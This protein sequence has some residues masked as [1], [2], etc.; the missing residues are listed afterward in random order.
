MNSFPAKMTAWTA[1][2]D[3]SFSDAMTTATPLGVLSEG[4]G[5]ALPSY[6]DMFL[7]NTGGCLG[8][9]LCT[10]TH[11]RRAFTLLHAAL[12]A[13]YPGHITQQQQR[14]F[15]LLG[16]DPLMDILSG[17]LLPA[18]FYGDRLHH[19]LSTSA[20]ASS[21]PLAAAC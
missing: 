20:H 21:M 7:G 16:R 15:P 13:G 4:T 5:A 3:H 18:R 14:R 10:R 6:L 8:Q 12:S 11:S 1:P 2:M 19:K 17:G 9:G